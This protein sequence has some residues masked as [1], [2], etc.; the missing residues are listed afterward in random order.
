M[1]YA[2]IGVIEMVRL[3]KLSVSPD[4]HAL[5]AGNAADPL[6][7]P[8]DDADQSEMC[9]TVSLVPPFV[10]EPDMDDMALD[11]AEADAIVACLRVVSPAAAA[12]APDA[13]GSA[14]WSLT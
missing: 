10:Q 3:V 5:D 12:V 9:E 1:G 11:P 2:A 4:A 13:P 7:V 8:A 6:K 14:V